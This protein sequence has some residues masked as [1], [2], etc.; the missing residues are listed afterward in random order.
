MPAKTSV[1]RRVFFRKLGI[2]GTTC[3]SGSALFSGCTQNPSNTIPRIVSEYSNVRVLDAF[4]RPNGSYIGDNWETLN[5]GFWKIKNGVLRRESP[6]GDAKNV[7]DWYP[8]HTPELEHSPSLLSRDPSLPFGMLWRRDWQLSGNY[9]V[10]LDF[11]I[12]NLPDWDTSSDRKHDKPGYAA[13]GICFGS[14][15]QFESGPGSQSEAAS[16]ARSMPQR[17][18]ATAT[19]TAW[20]LLLTDQGDFALFSHAIDDLIPFSDKAFVNF[21]ENDFPLTCSMGLFIWGDDSQYANITGFLSCNESIFTINVPSVN[22]IKFTN[23]YIGIASRGLLDVDFDQIATDPGT[24]FPLHAPMADL[25]ACY[26]LGDTLRLEEDGWHCTFV[27]LCRTTGESISIKVADTEY[28]IETWDNVPVAGQGL[29][30][31][32]DFRSN[33][34]LIDV[35]LPFEPAQ[36]A[37]FYTVWKDGINVTGDPRISTQSVSSGTGYRGQV[38]LDGN[39]VG[40]LPILKKPYRIC[41][42]SSHPIHDETGSLHNG[43]RFE[44]WYIH[45]QPSPQSFQHFERYNFQILLWEDGIWH[46]SSP[47]PPPTVEDAFKTIEVTLG[48]PTTRW[49]MM[50]HW[51]VLNPGDEEYGI[52]DNQGPEQYVVRTEQALGHDIGYPQRNFQITQ[53][54]CR[55]MASPNPTKNPSAWR[56]WRL[57]DK[58]LSVYVLDARSWRSSRNTRLW[59]HEGWGHVENLFSR[60]N[61][62][63]VLLGEEQY[64]WLTQQLKTDASAQICITGLNALHAIWTN[65]NE[66]DEADPTRVYNGQVNPSHASWVKEASDRILDLFGEREGI[67]SLYGGTGNASVLYNK[68]QRL[69]ES[70]FGPVSNSTFKHVKEGFAPLMQD[71]DGRSIEILAYYGPEHESPSSTPSGNRE[72]WN[73][74]EIECVPESGAGT[75]KLSIRNTRD[76]PN[77]PTRGGQD[78]QI[79]SSETGRIPT[80]ELPEILLIPNADVQIS[81]I[82]G[83]PIRGTR[84]GPD[85]TI[86][87]IKLVGVDTGINVLLVAYTSNQT[88]STIIRTKPITVS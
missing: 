66:L 76:L 25:Y 29:L 43:G 9:L 45:D 26:P 44:P 3:L 50:R 80:S 20:M 30:V 67:L 81:H 40:R 38:P 72:Y 52:T 22:R 84:T 62:T 32:N 39:Y 15:S 86:N 19:D 79:D 41:G 77:S 87:N 5:P 4:D 58:D 71:Y 49:Q 23:G 31:S 74:L 69:F 59:D 61:P 42:L 27:A 34:A 6:K 68:E 54:L 65:K 21:S 37:M 60:T 8:W 78:V 11:T 88:S 18:S 48:G 33:T 85:G 83:E 17:Q 13:V 12:H 46:L 63:R 73:F 82:T 24:N 2:L 57:P 10:Q 7:I 36:Q 64:S 70:C 55:G 53:H 28:P 16:F 1:T 14:V 51:N 35:T 56:K 47:Y 75:M